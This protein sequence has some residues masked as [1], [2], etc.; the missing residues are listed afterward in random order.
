MGIASAWFKLA[1]RDVADMDRLARSV[2]TIFPK[3]LVQPKSIELGLTRK[4]AHGQSEYQ[5][6]FQKIKNSIDG[7]LRHFDFIEVF[8]LPGEVS[9]ADGDL[10]IVVDPAQGLTLP[11]DEEA[12]TGHLDELFQRSRSW[13]RMPERPYA[14]V[15]CAFWGL[16]RICYVRA[17]GEVR[18]GWFLRERH[19]RYRTWIPILRVL[20]DFF[21]EAEN[22]FLLSIV[23]NSH[24]WSFT[25]TKCDEGDNWIPKT[26]LRAAKRNAELLANALAKIASTSPEAEVYWE[27]DKGDHMPDLAGIVGDEMELRF[28]AAMSYVDVNRTPAYM[29]RAELRS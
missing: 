27:I 15:K 14:S 3:V 6:D 8:P 16:T 22:E 24:A 10:S 19:Q 12:I 1:M 18:E 5:F 13:L 2:F 11:R 7:D 21:G 25:S 9:S 29:S 20:C 26:D 23:T 4:L 28:G 17:D